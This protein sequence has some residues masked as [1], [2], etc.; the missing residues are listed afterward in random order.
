MKLRVLL[1]PGMQRIKYGGRMGWPEGQGRGGPDLYNE[2]TEEQR[3][4]SMLDDG[5]LVHNK[6]D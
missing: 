2:L 5:E 4:G 3:K 6:C 1:P